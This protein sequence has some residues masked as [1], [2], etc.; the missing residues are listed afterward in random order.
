[1]D[2]VPEKGNRLPT[3]LYCGNKKGSVATPD[4]WLMEFIS[5]SDCVEHDYT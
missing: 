4:G 3:K 2:I 1:M 5:V